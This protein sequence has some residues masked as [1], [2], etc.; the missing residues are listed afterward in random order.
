[1]PKEEAV[2]PPSLARQFFEQFLAATDR[3]A[4]IRNLYDP[5]DPVSETDW[6]DFKQ[7]PSPNLK[8]PKWREMWVEALAG[9][10]NNAGGVLVWG[11]DARKDPATNVDAACGE[12]PVDNPSGLKSRLTELQR[13]ATDPPLANVEIEPVPLPADPGK[14]FVVCFIPEGPFKPYRTED[15]RRSQFPLRVATT[16]SS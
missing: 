8:D 3:V 15:G 16:S 6:L 9:F 13:Q 4:F 1:V 7:Q 5:A 10:A 2:P 14:G 11:I 12:R